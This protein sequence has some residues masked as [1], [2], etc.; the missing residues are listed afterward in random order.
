MMLGSASCQTSMRSR[1]SAPG[2]RRKLHGSANLAPVETLAYDDAR[3]AIT[4]CYICWTM[5]MQP[6]LTADLIRMFV[7]RILEE[8]FPDE[9]GAARLQE[10]G[11]FT[12]IYML[13][14][15][16]TPVTAARLAQM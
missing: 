10:V 6:D 2:N 14:N 12:M 8:V 15:D 5:L 16:P 11:L 1:G 13:Q 9:T 7:E 4:P 3:A